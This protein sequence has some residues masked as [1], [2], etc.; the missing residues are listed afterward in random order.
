[1]VTSTLTVKGQT[2]VPQEIR[3]ALGA[4]PHQRLVWELGKDGSVRVRAM[5]SVMELAGSLNSPVSF[6]GI[7]Q[8][9]DA[10]TAAWVSRPTK[11]ER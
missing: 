6:E 5:P 3:E 8:E 10:A 11:S 2:T 4:A 7:P 9:S 1:M